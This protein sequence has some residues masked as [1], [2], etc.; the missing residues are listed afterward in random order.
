MPSTEVIRSI[1]SGTATAGCSCA[2]F[3]RSNPR[4][5]LSGAPRPLVVR[6]ASVIITPA[7][8]TLLAFINISLLTVISTVVSASD[9]IRSLLV[10]PL[11]VVSLPKKLCQPDY[12]IPQQPP[13]CKL[14]AARNGNYKTDAQLLLSY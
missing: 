4:E 9:L 5:K 14:R 11:L 2:A 13:L 7:F 10:L 12:E 6:N 1:P 3:A 8:F